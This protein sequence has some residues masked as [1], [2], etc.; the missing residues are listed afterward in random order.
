MHK[1][2]INE[3]GAQQMAANSDST[4]SAQLNRGRIVECF[5]HVSQCPASAFF[6]PLSGIPPTKRNP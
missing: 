6:V 5:L 1:T 3:C 4:D 2:K